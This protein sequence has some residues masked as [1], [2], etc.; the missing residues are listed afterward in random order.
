M[1]VIN[2][3]DHP[4][5]QGLHAEIDDAWG[6]LSSSVHYEKAVMD[7]Q[8]SDAGKR[9]YDTGTRIPGRQKGK[10]DDYMSSRK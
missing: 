7:R 5:D 1:S 9:F 10:N 8:E 6:E 2:N 4:D 3:D